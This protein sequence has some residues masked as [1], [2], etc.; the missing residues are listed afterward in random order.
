MV[1]FPL[2][3]GL[4]DRRHYGIDVRATSDGQWVQLQ[5]DGRLTLEFDATNTC[6]VRVVER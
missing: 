1:R 4:A 2:T 3:D 5:A 6:R